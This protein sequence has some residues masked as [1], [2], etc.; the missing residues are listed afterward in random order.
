MTAAAALPVPFF[1]VAITTSESESLVFAAPDFVMAVD[2]EAELRP[3]LSGASM[4]IPEGVCL[5]FF[6]AASAPS[7]GELSLLLLSLSWPSAFEDELCSFLPLAVT[8]MVPEGMLAPAAL[9]VGATCAPAI[10]SLLLLPLAWPPNFEREL[11][12]LLPP[13]GSVVP[14]IAPESSMLD[15]SAAA[16]AGAGSAASPTAAMAA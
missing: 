3:L 4:A 5:L 2:F 14:R 10:E 7:L 9:A 11:C 6:L 8:V 15:A 12:L 1:L 13:A 16:D